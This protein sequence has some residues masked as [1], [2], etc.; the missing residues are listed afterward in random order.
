MPETLCQRDQKYTL[1]AKVAGIGIREVD[2]IRD[3]IT[4]DARAAMGPI[5][6]NR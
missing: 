4:L 1:G 5:F 3:T 6:K 2:Y